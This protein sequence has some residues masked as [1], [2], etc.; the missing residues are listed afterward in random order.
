M[1]KDTQSLPDMGG[2]AVSLLTMT[3]REESAAL[4]HLTRLLA[5]D[6]SKAPDEELADGIREAELAFAH[7][8]EW[9]GRLVAEMKRRGVSWSEL[10][11]LT[12]VPQSTLGRRAKDFL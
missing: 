3:S 7:S 8:P 6:I 11:K 1:W 10:Q 12:G 9:T 4:E 2:R 5:S